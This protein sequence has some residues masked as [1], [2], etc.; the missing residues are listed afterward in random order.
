MTRVSNVD[1]RRRARRLSSASQ[2]LAVDDDVVEAVD[3]GR[4]GRPVIGWIYAC[5]GVVD[6]LGVDDV[7]VGRLRGAGASAAGL[8]VGLAAAAS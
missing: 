2:E 7:V 4:V 5:V 3:S 1:L 6:D 8:A